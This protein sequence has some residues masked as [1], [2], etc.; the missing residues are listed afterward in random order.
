MD[1]FQFS[2][3]LDQDDYSHF[4]RYVVTAV[5]KAANLKAKVALHVWG[6]YFFIAITLSSLYFFIRHNNCCHL[7]NLYVALTGILFSVIFYFSYARKYYE[8]SLQ[9]FTSPEGL[10]RQAQQITVDDTG[11]TVVR[12]YST[13]SFQW[14]AIKSVV[15][16]DQ[17]ILLFVDACL[18][19][20]IPLR[21]FI[22]KESA[23]EFFSLV[24]KQIEAHRLG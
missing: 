20:T 23:D 24:K 18:A 11:I 6:F 4:A 7:E 1:K 22:S 14:L 13:E 12:K 9:H 17:H 15:Q 21:E 3:E 5:D 2:F 16:T 10:Y 8:L 19:I